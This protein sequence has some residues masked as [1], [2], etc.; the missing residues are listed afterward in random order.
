MDELIKVV[1]C[2]FV[3]F[4]LYKGYIFFF[5]TVFNTCKSGFIEI[6]FNNCCNFYDDYCDDDYESN[7]EDF[8]EHK[9]NVLPKRKRYCEEDD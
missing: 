9:R 6:F 3:F 1:C 2:G 4:V 8:S 5:K 7:G